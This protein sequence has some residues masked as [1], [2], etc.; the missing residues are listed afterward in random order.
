MID[1]VTLDGLQL[2]SCYVLAEVTVLHGRRQFGEPTAAM[3]AT[4]RV[5]VPAGSMPSQGIG[6]ILYLDGPAGRMFAGRVVDV[7]LE[8]FTNNDG[9]VWGLFTVTAAGPV[10]ALGVR[11]V[12]DVPWPQELD[13][14]RAGRILA[15][16]GVASWR[17]EGVPG[18]FSYNGGGPL[19]VLARDVDS[20]PAGG[21]LDEL[22][23]WTSAAVFDTPAGEVVYQ[24]LASRTRVRPFRW[25][26]YTGTWSG[27]GATLLWSD[28]VGV[29]SPASQY[30]TVLPCD[31][32]EWEPRWVLTEANILNHVAIGYGAAE[33]QATVDLS[34]SASIGAHN[35]RYAY[36]GTQLAGLDDAIEQ[37]S[38]LISTRARQRWELDEVTV[39]LD[40]L[41]PDLYA[42]V[43]G[44]TCGD[45]VVL[46]G[47]PQ[48]APATDWPS[49]VEGWTFTQYGQ[50]GALSERITL[51][52]SD[53]LLSV[54]LPTWDDYWNE[55]GMTWAAHDP[56]W[57]WADMDWD[58]VLP[59]EERSVW[60]A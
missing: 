16:S 9:T 20:Q 23:S 17:V 1:T 15:A 11:P 32:V 55:P 31:V 29:A 57:T 12:G 58:L 54:I 13:T 59:A 44:L 24:T 33:P 48:P 22:A 26:D 52:L 60:A 19:N 49:V 7:S 43:L 18:D 56:D 41:P 14:A 51:S 30:P 8:H 3:S 37:A 10:A 28:L 25:V 39:A 47:L 21:L 5:E 42:A 46:Q 27:I 50:A 4:I 36:L 45:Q 38:R 6:A 53:P 34:D 2:D 35:V 40:L